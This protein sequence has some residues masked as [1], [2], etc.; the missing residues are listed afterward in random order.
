MRPYAD[1][2]LKN[3][4]GPTTIPMRVSICASSGSK[5]TEL[6]DHAH[7]VTVFLRRRFVDR[8]YAGFTP[9][10]LQVQRF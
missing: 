1:Q 10:A 5:K 6:S 9:G 2:V 4:V 3:L 8:Y 7:V